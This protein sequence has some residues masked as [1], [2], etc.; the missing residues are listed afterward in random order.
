MFHVS[1]SRITKAKLINFTGYIE[2]KDDNI[3][4]HISFLSDH[5]REELKT[6]NGKR[7][8][9][10]Y[11]IGFFLYSLYYKVTKRNARETIKRYALLH[12]A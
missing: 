9:H 10:S 11:Y 1:N 3:L 8:L 5:I 6:F 7:K 12:I 2:I 4:N